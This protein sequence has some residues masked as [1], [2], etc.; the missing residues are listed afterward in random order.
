MRI[1]IPIE[2]DRG[3]DSKVCAHF[4]GAPA[5][6]VVDTEQNT[7]EALSNAH[8]HAAHGQCVPVDML[9]ER[10]LDAMLVSGIGR[11]AIM[12]LGS[13]GLRVFRAEGETVGQSV[14]ALLARGSAEVGTEEACAGHEHGGCDGE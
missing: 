5:F 9:A 12:K 11:G 14:E 7:Y 2:E 1:A 6:L 3:R 13:L 4:G 8:D 10:K